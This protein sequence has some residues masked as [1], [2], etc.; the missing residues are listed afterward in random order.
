[1]TTLQSYKRFDG[2]N[3]S[4]GDIDTFLR[5][6]NLHD[7]RDDWIISIRQIKIYAYRS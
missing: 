4:F 1:M 5:E 6:W 2:K 3:D 7:W